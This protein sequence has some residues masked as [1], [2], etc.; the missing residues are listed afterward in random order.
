MRLQDYH[1]RLKEI[2]LHEAVK[3]M[4][5]HQVFYNYEVGKT[6]FQLHTE[7]LPSAILGEAK[8][9]T[10]DS[11]LELDKDLII[12]SPNQKKLK[13]IN[14][15][16]WEAMDKLIEVDGYSDLTLHLEGSYYEICDML[17]SSS[18]KNK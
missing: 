11:W 2:T 1:L 18:I 13:V 8:Y 17:E 16:I 14:E 10:P 7:S 15:T 5:S 9:F 3:K 12:E 4:E 6:L